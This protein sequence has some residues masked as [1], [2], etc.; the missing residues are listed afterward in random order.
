MARAK[1]WG[2]S[3]P[4]AL[5]TATSTGTRPVPG[6]T[7]GSTSRTTAPRGAGA[8][9]GHHHLDGLAGP[10]RSGL[11]LGEGGVEDEQAVG[12]DGHQH[13]PGGDGDPGAVR[14]PGDDAGEGGLEGVLLEVHLGL[15]E[16]GLRGP[17]LGLRQVALALGLDELRLGDRLLGA[18]ALGAL[19]G[20]LGQARLGPRR[21]QAGLGLGHGRPGSRRRRGA[22]AGPPR[23]RPG[24]A[25][26]APS[27]AC[28]A[29]GKA[30][31]EASRAFSTP[32][33]STRGV[34]RTFSGTSSRTVTA[35]G[36]VAAALAGAPAGGAWG[37][38]RPH[39]ATRRAASAATAR[40]RIMSGQGAAS[41]AAK[42]RVRRSMAMLR[43]GRSA[44]WPGTASHATRSPG[45]A[46]TTT[47]TKA[48]TKTAS[49]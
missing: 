38:F 40:A 28:P 35:E 10:E 16:G 37:S 1:A 47:T 19:E 9:L 11:V 36:A 3:R 26:P 25:G 14:H 18:E 21:G 5:G 44:I 7:D 22:R 34:K 49:A 33:A 13:L 4:S 2:R 6:S 24:P 32:V 41:A 45:G 43:R 17:G 29:M 15:A 39:A 31:C 42:R 27:A 23:P 8:G 48:R 46:S 30:S 12:L 20:V